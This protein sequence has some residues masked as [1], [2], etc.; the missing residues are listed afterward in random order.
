MGGLESVRLSDA[1]ESLPSGFHVIG[2]AAYPL[3]EKRPTVVDCF[4]SVGFRQLCT[5]G[6]SDFST[7]TLQNSNLLKFAS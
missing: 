6:A 4:L 1:V 7:E 2:D 3:S 5:W